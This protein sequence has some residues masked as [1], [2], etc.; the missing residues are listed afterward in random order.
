MDFSLPAAVCVKFEGEHHRAN[1]E[2]YPL[3]AAAIF[4]KRFGMFD[5]VQHL[6]FWFRHDSVHP[7]EDY[8]AA[9]AL[10]GL[11]CLESVPVGIDLPTCLYRIL[12]GQAFTGSDINEL[13]PQI[14]SQLRQLWDWRAEGGDVG[15]AGLTFRAG[16]G[17]IVQ[18][19]NE[20]LDE[21]VAWCMK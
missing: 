1:R 11:A 9:G 21:Y 8:A 17:E 2:F 16:T 6:F 13:A 19:C 14:G 15:A 3:A 12:L 4:D 7:A 5:L 18:V 20:N 10:L